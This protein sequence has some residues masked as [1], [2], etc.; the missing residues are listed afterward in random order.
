[1]ADIKNTEEEEKKERARRRRVEKNLE[2]LGTEIRDFVDFQR[3][4]FDTFKRSASFKKY[5][6][7]ETYIPE[8][9]KSIKAD[10][11]RLL[12]GRFKE[13]K[14]RKAMLDENGNVMY[15][16]NG[17]KKMYDPSD[18]RFLT[19]LKR[20]G[21]TSVG[22]YLSDDKEGIVYDILRTMTGRLG[23]DF[24]KKLKSQERYQKK[25]EEFGTQP[26]SPSSNPSSNG[27][28]GGVNRPPIDSL[29]A[30]AVQQQDTEKL[31]M[32]MKDSTDRILESTDEIAILAKSTLAIDKKILAT[33]SKRGITSLEKELEAKKSSDEMVDALKGIEKNTKNTVAMVAKSAGGA[34]GSGGMIDNITD[35]ATTAILGKGIFGKILGK[36]KGFGTSTVGMLKRGAQVG[37]NKALPLFHSIGDKTKS[38]GT[39]A[40][41]K[42]KVVGTNLLDKGKSLLDKGRTLADSNVSPIKTMAKRLSFVGAGITAI[43]S[44]FDINK[45]S[46]EI[47]EKVKSGVISKE[48]ANKAKVNKAIEIGSSGVGSAVG[49]LVGTAKG[50]ALGATLG[51]VVPV[52]GTGIGAI[53]GGLVGGFGGG[54]L[55]EKLGGLVGDAVTDDVKERKSFAERA[56]ELANERKEVEIL[57]KKTANKLYLKELDTLA[58]AGVIEKVRGKD[59]SVSYKGEN[60]GAFKM[61]EARY[62]A[63]ASAFYSMAE[64]HLAISDKETALAKERRLAIESIDSKNISPSNKNQEHLNMANESDRANFEQKQREAKKDSASEK[65]VNNNVH[66]EVKNQTFNNNPL[67][68][69]SDMSIHNRLASLSDY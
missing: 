53:L 57:E 23:D 29:N 18:N 4:S 62:M 16:E 22:R 37:T 68:P 65:T 52:I 56:Q 26:Q 54:W 69:R 9:D 50:A 49:G 40:L 43:S 63:D 35:V 30:I 33:Q 11:A 59:G 15:D 13:K 17:N 42:G 1:M 41:E 45:A 32:T 3:F 46:D 34:D 12:V 14:R 66:T 47:D 10:V 67:K 6:T 28:S 48:D 51:S 7:L 5:T 27:K 21:L 38:I 2:R 39:S 58:E 61:E 24:N 60:H 36:V 44:I 25:L 20:S 31:V 64:K 55:G 19:R 8:S